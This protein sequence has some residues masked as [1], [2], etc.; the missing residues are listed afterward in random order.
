MSSL[1]EIQKIKEV[2]APIRELN[3]LLFQLLAEDADRVGMTAQQL[4]VLSEIYKN[5]E[6]GLEHLSENIQLSNSTLSGIVD[7][8]VKSGLLVRERSTRDR[9]HLELRVS[10]IGEEKHRTAF[11]PAQSVVLQRMAYALDI[12]SE[13]L[14]T[15]F[16]IQRKLLE[17]L[18]HPN[19]ATP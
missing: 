4:L 5:P 3:K 17:R 14:E 6:V 19:P 18:R 13:E 12:P 9:R 15:M 8:M 2:T 7:R 10:P 11:D 16:R 1:Q